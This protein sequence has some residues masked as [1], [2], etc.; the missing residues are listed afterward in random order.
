MGYR[1]N[2]EDPEHHL[3]F[4]GT[5]L[6]GYVDERSLESYK[7]LRSIEKVNDDTMFCDC[8]DN[9]CTLTPE[10][11]AKF[12]SLYEEDYFKDAGYK[13]NTHPKYEAIEEMLKTN[14]DK[15]ISWG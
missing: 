11:F 10:Q 4:Y 1:L 13:M 7:Y 3:N 14:S 8:W 15:I 5:K 12:I 2:I 6:Y 9:E